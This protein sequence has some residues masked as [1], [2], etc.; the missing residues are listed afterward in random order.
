MSLGLP[1]TNPLRVMGPSL[2]ALFCGLTLCLF[3]LLAGC[4][5]LDKR[6]ARNEE[7]LKDLPAEHQGLIRQG[8][9]QVGFTPT[10]VYLAWGAP[11]HKA[12]TENAQGS[13][14]TWSYTSTQAETY[15]REERYYDR[16]FDTWRSTDRPYQRYLEYIFQEAIFSNGTL[17]SFTLY[18]SSKPYLSGQSVR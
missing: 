12:F 18:P 3:L 6:L 8:R 2:L 4:E 5:T 15:Y 14:E 10:E 17:S 9:I 16:K 11:T 1:P 7:V 13:E